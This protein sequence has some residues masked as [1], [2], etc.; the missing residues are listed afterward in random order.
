MDIP[1]AGIVGANALADGSVAPLAFLQ[2]I[3]PR[4]A[5]AATCRHHGHVPH[6]GP[7]RRRSGDRLRSTRAVSMTS[8]HP[9]DRL[10]AIDDRWVEMVRP[11]QLDRRLAPTNLA[12]ER[13]SFLDAWRRGEFVEPTFTYE[14]ADPADRSALEAF[15]RSLRPEECDVEGKYDTL[16]GQL[17]EQIAFLDDRSAERLAAWTTKIYGTPDDDL[18]VRAEKILEEP[19]PHVGA[20]PTITA[21]SAAERLREGLATGGYEGWTVEVDP[22]MN[23]RM[24]VDALRRRMR[25]RAGARFTPQAVDRLLVHEIGVHVHRAHCGSRQPLRLLGRGLPGYL[26]T[27]EGLAVWSER[28]SNLLDPGTLRVYAARVVAAR[29]SLDSGFVDVFRAVEPRV[30]AEAAF[31]IAARSKRGLEDPSVPGGH[32]KDQVYLRGFLEVSR[33]LETN[34]DDLPLL[35]SAKIGLGDLAFFETLIHRGLAVVHGADSSSEGPS[36][37]SD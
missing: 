20:S 19:P 31:E 11:L 12:T 17:L 28:E 18:L 32:V 7:T 1:V 27:E 34:P 26:A 25:V 36:R 9:A 21:S 33:H 24:S 14:S 37:C 35:K 15:R 10:N 22:I 4:R 8:S 5:G 29:T 30:G 3:T 6:F 16:T 2:N 23:A 13:I